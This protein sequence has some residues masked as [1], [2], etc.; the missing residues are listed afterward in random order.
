MYAEY[1]QLKLSNTLVLSVHRQTSYRDKPTNATKV[2]QT[3]VLRDKRTT[4]TKVLQGHLLS[5]TC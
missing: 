5:K 1:L 4:G 3:N 2:L